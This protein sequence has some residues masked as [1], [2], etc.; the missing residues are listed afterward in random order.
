MPAAR[1]AAQALDT[2]EGGT[3]VTGNGESAT[4]A[5]AWAGSTL[6]RFAGQAGPAQAV[7]VMRPTPDTARLAYMMLAG[8]G[9]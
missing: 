2:G 5:L 8:M 3:V 9:A 4:D 6:G 1:Y 7:N